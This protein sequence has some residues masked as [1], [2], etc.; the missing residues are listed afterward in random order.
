MS[1][2][3]QDKYIL[4]LDCGHNPSV[5]FREVQFDERGGQ[6]MTRIQA[7]VWECK[8]CP[9]PIPAMER[10]KLSAQQLYRQAGEP[11]IT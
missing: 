8:D 2:R 7:G 6:I 10:E 3:G 1:S 4:Q 11:D 5:S 9:D